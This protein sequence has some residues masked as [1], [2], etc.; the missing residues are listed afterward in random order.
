MTLGTICLFKSKIFSDCYNGCAWRI[1]AKT[2]TALILIRHHS[3]ATPSTF[4]TKQIMLLNKLG[5]VSSLRTSGLVLSLKQI[6]NFIV[7]FYLF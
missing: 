3:S 4:L 5:P 2:S 7:D 6:K 1:R